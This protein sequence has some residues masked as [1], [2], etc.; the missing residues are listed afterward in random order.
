MVI[1]SPGTYFVTKSAR[2][3]VGVQL[4]VSDLHF[5]VIG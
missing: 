2:N 1:G 3:L 5:F 4:K